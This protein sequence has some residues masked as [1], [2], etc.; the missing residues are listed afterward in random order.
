M[1][2]LGNTFL[3]RAF[4]SPLF[5]DFLGFGLPLGSLRGPSGALLGDFWRLF[6][7]VNF[8]SLLGLFLGGGRRQ[9][10]GLSKSSDSADS[11]QRFHHALLP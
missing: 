9:G 10:R 8:L 1:H 7:E 11:A 2:H 6:S 3:K 5:A 4:W